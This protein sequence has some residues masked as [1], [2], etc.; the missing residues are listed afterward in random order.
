MLQKGATMTRYTYLHKRRGVYYIRVGIPNSI[1]NILKKSEISYSLK[2]K[3][4]REAVKKLK[5]EILTVDKLFE[6]SRNNLHILT[7]SELIS[8]IK[9]RMSC[10]YWDSKTL[11]AM[12]ILSPEFDT[13]AKQCLNLPSDINFDKTTDIW[14]T[15]YNTML[16][17]NDC[18]KDIQD[19]IDNG[20][21]G[22]DAYCKLNDIVEK[23]SFIKEENSTV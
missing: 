11:T 20:N 19:D 22:V 13:Y 8:I 7:K 12:Q 23:L 9:Y 2:T 21:S 1:R 10:I 16:E 17:M 4:Y 5:I 14:K 6:D 15:Y 3:D 18:I